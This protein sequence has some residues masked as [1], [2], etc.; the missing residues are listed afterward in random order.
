MLKRF[1]PGDVVVF[2]KYKRSTSPGPRARNIE[3]SKRGEEYS[4]VV[5]KFWMVVNVDE[6]GALHLETRRGKK[7]CVEISDPCLRKPTVWERI[8]LRHKFPPAA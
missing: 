3:A 4:Y 1:K 5:D 6:N 8:A 7:H 2:K